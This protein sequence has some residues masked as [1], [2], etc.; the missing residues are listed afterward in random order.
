[1]FPQYRVFIAHAGADEQVAREV[2]AV[3][4]GSSF[5]V[6]IDKNPENLPAGS[7]FRDRIG[8][9]IARCDLFIVLLS[10]AMANDPKKYVWTEV[11]LAHQRFKKPQGH[12]LAFVVD[13]AGDAQAHDAIVAG[14]R[15]IEPW[16]TENLSIPNSLGNTSA[17]IARAA[18][19]MR[20]HAQSRRMWQLAIAGIFV[21]LATVAWPSTSTP[22]RD[23]SSSQHLFD[24]TASIPP[25]L[26]PF[27]ASSSVVWLTAPQPSGSAWI[28]PQPAT[29]LKP[30]VRCY[31]NESPLKRRFAACEHGSRPPTNDERLPLRQQYPD[32]SIFTV[33]KP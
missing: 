6:F 33:C 11:S 29:S 13:D 5:E 12:V 22:K 8:N 27:S 17:A 9:A 1:M 7:E 2:A 21:V 4:E 16:L 31:I 26:P 25:P 28:P 32:C 18:G 15:R 3:L 10:H 23:A 20:K 14:V 19:E 24:V 30:V